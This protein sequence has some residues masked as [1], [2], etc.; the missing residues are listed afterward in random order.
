M[1]SFALIV[2]YLLILIALA[3]FVHKRLL[4]NGFPGA[5]NGFVLGSILYYVIV[6]IILIIFKS[7]YLNQAGDWRYNQLLHFV[8]G[9]DVK[10]SNILF[11]IGGL[12]I[13]MIAFHF[14]YALSR[15]SRNNNIINYL[16]IEENKLIIKKAALTTFIIGSIAIFIYISAFG[17]L[18]NTLQL[19]EVLRQH[20][21][22]ISDYGLSSVYSYFLIL[23]GALSLAPVLLYLNAKN[24]QR[25][26][27]YFLFYCSLIIA[28]IYMLI[29]SG[30]SAFL[31]L[32]IVFIYI[33]M[34]EKR[35]KNK[36][37]YFIIIIALGLPIMDVLDA[38]F[39]QESVVFAL[40]N[41]NYLYLVREFSIPTELSYNMNAIV[42]RYGYLYFKNLI[43]D[44]LDILPGL[45]FEQSFRN[46]SEFVR[47]PNWM[48]LG[49]TPND[50]LTY[51][52]LQYRY[53]GVF[54]IWLIWGGIC[55]WLD[56]LI[57][58]IYDNRGKHVLA[59]FVC[60][61]VFSVITCADI[62]STILYNLSFVIVSYVLWRYSKSIN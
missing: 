55:G 7:Y 47:G 49:G 4:I 19:S 38:V 34:F 51:G 1:E 54:V 37:V 20:Y 5:Y 32:A 2:L 56:T 39:A 36:W 62:S 24:T 21:S 57:S 40:K 17:G 15:K 25:K 16:I 50:V 48:N 6:P 41:F 61:N 45:Q 26:G 3:S 30:K 28:F 18:K 35:I 33:F 12:I 8:Y 14:G 9:Y 13:G 22:S 10:L 29:N 42:E 46:T 59:I 53:I 31:R 11:A 44:F 27:D 60:M 58:R 43:T 52:F 23:S